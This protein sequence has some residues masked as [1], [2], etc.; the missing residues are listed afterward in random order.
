MS[1]ALTRCSWPCDASVSASEA[2][3]SCSS[4]DDKLLA[5]L[6]RLLPVTLLSEPLFLTWLGVC[7]VFIFEPCRFLDVDCVSFGVGCRLDVFFGIGV[8][9][10]NMSGDCVCLDR[11]GDTELSC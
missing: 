8:F 3:L 2:L 7:C 9:G 4:G 1:N 10:F 6:F 5:D 11:N